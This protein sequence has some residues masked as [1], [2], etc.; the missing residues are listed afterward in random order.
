MRGST[1][2]LAPLLQ[3]ALTEQLDNGLTVI[4]HPIP[5]SSAVT[6]DVWV[7]TGGRYEPDEWVGI[8]HFLEHMVFK[9]TDRL[10][11]GE[12]DLAIEGRGGMTNAAT[13]QD[14]THYF[15]TVA[16][17]D[18]ADTLPYL[19]EVLLRASIPG[20]EFERERQVVLEEMRRAA[21]NPDY[22]AY[23]QLLQTA[24]QVHPYR[25]SVLGTAASVMGLTPQLMR[26]YH[27][28]WYQPQQMT[29]V[30]T[31]QLEAEPALE[32]V[33]R[34]FGAPGASLPPSSPP[35]PQESPLQEIRRCPMTLPRLEQ[36]RLLMAWPTVSVCDWEIACGLEFLASLLG[37]GRT[38]RLTRILR[39]QR[40]WVQGVGCSSIAQQDPGLFYISSYL[41]PLHV[42]VVEATILDQISQLQEGDLTRE[43]LERTR[44]I[45]LNEFT[46]STESPGQLASIFGYYDSVARWSGFTGPQMDLASQYL[47]TVQTM[48]S[49]QLQAL[50]QQY[51]PIDQYVVVTLNPE[52]SPAA[53]TPTPQLVLC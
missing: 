41:D 7:R 32:L 35:I 17:A 39:E 3:P 27:Q 26:D 25:R 33:K 43:E 44:R 8:S 6:V 49:E 52:F 28:Q 9:G 50:A 51:L 38:S 18:L 19:A 23:H 14:Y 24:Y 11:P 29:V 34:Y 40:G 4:I 20:D 46:F 1:L 2:N 36:T 21:D 22:V 30:I 53:S 15:I 16:A 5:I 47:E 31:G 13:S 45:L 48:T 10:A 37:D 42:E 12:L